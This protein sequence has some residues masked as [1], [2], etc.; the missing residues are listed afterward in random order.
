MICPRCNEDFSSRKY[1]IA[2][3]NPIVKEA[4]CPACHHKF[5]APLRADKRRLIREILTD[6]LLDA[7]EWRKGD[8]VER[9]KIL[10]DR[11]KSIS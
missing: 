11:V 2:W 10:V 3:P 4:T 9:V 8:T 7:E 1:S 5:E 6:D